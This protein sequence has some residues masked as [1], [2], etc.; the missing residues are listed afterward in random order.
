MRV[1]TK[2][3]HL[4]RTSRVFPFITVTNWQKVSETG[5][6]V[7]SSLQVITTCHQI[8][9]LPSGPDHVSGICSSLAG[10]KQ[11]S[12]PCGNPSVRGFWLQHDPVLI[13]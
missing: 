10:A 13:E 4:L 3:W 8:M 12:E 7:G 2:T 5:G 1:N 6:I 11:P 9:Y